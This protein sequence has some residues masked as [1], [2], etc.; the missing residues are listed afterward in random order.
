MNS[1][2]GLRALRALVQVTGDRAD[3]VEERSA[4]RAQ[5]RADAGGASGSP[6]RTS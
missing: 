6:V 1:A 2:R 5:N 3:G 4:G